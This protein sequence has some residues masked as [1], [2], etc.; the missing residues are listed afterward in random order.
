MLYLLLARFNAHVILYYSIPRCC[1]DPGS[2]FPRRARLHLRIISR[3][4]SAVFARSAGF[5]DGPTAIF[6]AS[7]IV[8]GTDTSPLLLKH[9]ERDVTCDNQ[10][11][12]SQPH[13]PTGAFP[14]C[15]A[16]AEFGGGQP[17]CPPSGAAP[18]RARAGASATGRVGYDT[19]GEQWIILKTFMWIQHM[20]LMIVLVIVTLGLLGVQQACGGCRGG[21][22]RGGNIG[23]HVE[24]HGSRRVV[25]LSGVP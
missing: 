4:S 16:P 6:L 2:S 23:A 17:P 3:A 18:C 19:G 15:R 12:C 8:P 22:A 1:A 21:H 7:Q 13:A 9:R 24:A 14:S 20:Q 10:H 11:S 5:S 25:V